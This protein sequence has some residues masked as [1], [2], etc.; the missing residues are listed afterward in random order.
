MILLII[1]PV[2]PLLTWLIFTYVFPQL[3]NIA[4][5]MADAPGAHW[6][7]FIGWLPVALG[8]QLLMVV[9]ANVLL[10]GYVG[11]P[12]LKAWIQDLTFPFIDAFVWHM[13]WRRK[14]LQRDFAT[15]LALLLDAQVP[16]PKALLLA[17]NSTANQYFIRRVQTAA[18]TLAQGQPLTEAVQRL[19]ETGEFRWRLEKRGSLHPRFQGALGGWLETLD[20]RA[21]QQEQAA[22]QGLTTVTVLINGL[23]VATVGLS[24]FSVLIHL[25]QEAVLW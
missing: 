6:A 14:R 11:G 22:A 9:C 25:I 17:A 4:K 12:R 23:L 20:A 15:M 7:G 10:I 13:P 2:L 3:L 1:G 16:E 8:M 19:D 21:F 5:E 24:V 18:E